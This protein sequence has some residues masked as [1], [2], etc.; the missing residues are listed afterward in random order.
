[1]TNIKDKSS[2]DDNPIKVNTMICE[3]ELKI[4]KWNI[5]EMFLVFINIFVICLELK[6]NGMENK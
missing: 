1:M 6:M 5:I 4:H 3:K 2:C